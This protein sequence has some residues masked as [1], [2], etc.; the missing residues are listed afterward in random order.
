MLSAAGPLNST[1]AEEGPRW[2]ADDKTLYFD[3]TR[4]GA[5]S[6]WRSS[7]VGSTFGTPQKLTELA[8]DT[9]DAVP[10]LS[11]DELTINFLS[12]RAPTPD[13]DIYVA[14]RSSRTLPFANVQVLA[15]V[16]SPALD[17]PSY[18]SADGCTLY[19]GSLRGTGKFDAFVA[20]RPN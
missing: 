5:R 17:A 9:L 12:T 13:G 2:A 3:S 6:I 20:R 1:A 16:N 18:I 11:P 8:S 10:V 15:N 19:L 7:V 14:T 4:G